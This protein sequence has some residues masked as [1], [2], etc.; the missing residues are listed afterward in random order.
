VGFSLIGLGKNVQYIAVNKEK[1]PYSFSIK[2]VDR[3]YKFTFKWNDLGEFYTCDLESAKDGVL[4]YGDILRYGRPIFGSIEDERYPLPVIIPFCFSGSEI[5]EI[6][7]DNF[8]EQ[9]KLYLYNRS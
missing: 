2:L 8:G 5:S 9:V 7:K 3:T 4:C 1:I 6:T